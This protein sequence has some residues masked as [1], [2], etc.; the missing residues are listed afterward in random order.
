MK[1][2]QSH[3]DESL[4]APDSTDTDKVVDRVARTL[5]VEKFFDNCFFL[6]S[7]KYTA[8]E[9]NKK[10]GYRLNGTSL[11][12]FTKKLPIYKDNIGFS[13]WENDFGFT[14]DIPDKVWATAGLEFRGFTEDDFTG[15]FTKMDTPDFFKIKNLYIFSAGHLKSLKGLGR[16]IANDIYIEDSNIEN[17]TISSRPKYTEDY[18][19]VTK[20]INVLKCDIK[21]VVDVVADSRISFHHCAIANI[22]QITTNSTNHS[23]VNFDYCDFGPSAFSHADIQSQSL[24]NFYECKLKDFSGANFFA[25]QGLKLSRMLDLKTL[26]AC[27]I[28]CHTLSI[29]YCNQITS[30]KDIKS[31]DCP[32]VALFDSDGFTSFEGLPD[33][34]STLRV[35]YCKIDY[36]KFNM[37][38]FPKVT[39]ALSWIRNL[40][41]KIPNE[42]LKFLRDKSKGAA[43]SI[44]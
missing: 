6:G 34:L 9:F 31:I 8:D 21:N 42:F 27:K 16:F 35:E 38:G 29:E 33:E 11:E 26:G 10:F 22:S 4:F 7:Y 1:S 2:L 3:I 37:K 19:C 44:T 25:N 36:N 15:V 12:L 5:M 32:C 20:I 14:I 28:K 17:L 41:Q 39:G 23:G 18:P 40:S 13:Y 24:I 30:F 43:A